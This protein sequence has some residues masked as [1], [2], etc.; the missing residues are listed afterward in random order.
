MF[1]SLIDNKLNISQG[2]TLAAKQANS[3]PRCSKQSM[4]SRLRQAVLLLYSAL[5][6]YI[7]S[8]ELP[9]EERHDHNGSTSAKD[10]KDD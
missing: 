10:H 1:I 6:R 8:P 3:L 2:C 4:A 9:A 7:W 5:V